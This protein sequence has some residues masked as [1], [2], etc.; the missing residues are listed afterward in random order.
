MVKRKWKYIQAQRQR[1][2]Q[3]FLCSK[4]CLVFPLVCVCPG[5]EVNPMLGLLCFVVR[6]V[7]QTGNIIALPV[8]DNFVA[9]DYNR[10]WQVDLP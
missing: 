5:S 9:S 3:G 6:R 4:T 1:Q 8:D 7:S 2:T 10:S